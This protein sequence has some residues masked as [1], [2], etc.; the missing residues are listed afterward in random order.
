MLPGLESYM[1]EERSGFAALALGSQYPHACTSFDQPA[2]YSVSVGGSPERSLLFVVLSGKDR[3]EDINWRIYVNEVKVSRV[4]KP[5]HFLKTRS[6]LYYA[7]VADVSPVTKNTETVEILVKCHAASTLVESAGLVLLLSEEFQSK[8]G[9]HIGISRVE[10]EY[11]LRLADGFSVISIA[12]RGE[13]G[14]ITAGGSSKKVNSL[15]EFSEL[16]TDNSVSIRG[17]ANV[18]VVVTNTYAGRMPELLIEDSSVEPDRV[19]VVLANT[20]DYSASNVDLRLMR[21]TTSVSRS[22]LKQVRPKESLELALSK[23][24]SDIGAIKVT[25]EFSGHVFTRVFPIKSP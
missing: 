6:D 14:T 10:G 8:V 24:A 16:V 7:Y 17:P 20:G 5:Q 21:G 19:R 22:F 4:F 15:F 1:N 25:Y 23:P 11:S 9:I 3:V 12:G 2:R 18:Y 13:G